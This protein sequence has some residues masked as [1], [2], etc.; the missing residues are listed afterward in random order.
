MLTVQDTPQ[1]DNGNDCGIFS[2]QTLEAL[3]RGK[4]LAQGE[5]EFTAQN[6]P[7]FRRMMVYEIAKGEMYKRW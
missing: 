4:D 2:C 7:F 6:M 1:Q 5:W 3:A